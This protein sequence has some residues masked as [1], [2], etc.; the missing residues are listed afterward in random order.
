M[1]IC[2]KKGSALCGLRH[3]SVHFLQLIKL[4]SC[5]TLILTS[6][7]E[8]QPHSHYYQPI[9]QYTDDVSNDESEDNNLCLGDT[10]KP[11]SYNFVY[12]M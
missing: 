3:I 7:I 9:Q 6:G 1:Y 2:E 5:N 11:A 10:V 4:G 8:D 12:F